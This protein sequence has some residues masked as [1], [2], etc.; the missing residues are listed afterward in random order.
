GLSVDDCLQQSD[1]DMRATMPGE[2]RLID[3]TFEQPAR[4]KADRDQA[5]GGDNEPY[6][7]RARLGLGAC[8][9]RHTEIDRT[10][11]RG[12]PA[13]ALDLADFQL[14]R[15]GEAG[16]TRNLL[17]LIRRWLGQIDPLRL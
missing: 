6:R 11:S 12:E 14:G 13:G 1:Q 15:D 9:Q 10:I 5:L 17:D 4:R 16:L 3:E 2:N 7:D 8:D